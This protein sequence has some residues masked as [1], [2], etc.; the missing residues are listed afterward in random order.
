LLRLAEAFTPE[1]TRNPSDRL[2]PVEVR[3]SESSPEELAKTS[4]QLDDHDK[5]H[6]ASAQ[7]E[8]Q[9]PGHD[10]ESDGG[11]EDTVGEEV[12]RDLPGAAFQK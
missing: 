8:D 3:M 11:G 12:E 7:E 5:E 2:K 10:L 9:A 6:D 4:D 1:E